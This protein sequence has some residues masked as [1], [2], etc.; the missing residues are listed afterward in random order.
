MLT[1]NGTLSQVGQD[2]DP[3]R[4]KQE[5][6]E[7]V[8]MLDC[9]LADDYCEAIIVV[10]IRLYETDGAAMKTHANLTT[11]AV[12]ISLSLVLLLASRRLPRRGETGL[13]AADSAASQAPQSLIFSQEVEAGT[14]L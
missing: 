13:G 2:R 6:A 4:L 12:G 10:Y 5:F 9:S 11:T 3:V 7:M 1:L 14:C 8:K